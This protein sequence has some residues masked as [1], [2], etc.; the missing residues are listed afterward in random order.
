MRCISTLDDSAFRFAIRKDDALAL[1]LTN[2]AGQPLGI[3]LFFSIL[4]DSTICP[5]ICRDDDNP[6]LATGQLGSLQ[7]IVIDYN[8]L[9][10]GL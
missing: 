7:S 4:D 2:A 9:N 8:S 10:R 3:V 6:L 1:L 5:A